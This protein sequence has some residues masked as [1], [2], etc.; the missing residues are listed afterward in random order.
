MARGASWGQ[1]VEG[2]RPGLVAGHGGEGG[3]AFQDTL[4][5]GQVGNDF[6]PTGQ[7]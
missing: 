6:L 1:I 7:A 2:E 5:R 4:L 3:A